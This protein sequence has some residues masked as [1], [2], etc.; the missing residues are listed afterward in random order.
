MSWAS[1][2]VAAIK[3]ARGDWCQSDRAQKHLRWTMTLPASLY[4]SLEIHICQ[5]ATKSRYVADS[6]RPSGPTV[7]SC[8]GPLMQCAHLRTVHKVSLNRILMPNQIDPYALLLAHTCWKV[9]RDA[10]MA[11]PTKTEYCRSPG[12]TV[13]TCQ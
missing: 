7:A 11:A 5:C 10:R 3:S 8:A 13:L 9:V 4:S 12:A 1:A 2:A 6:T